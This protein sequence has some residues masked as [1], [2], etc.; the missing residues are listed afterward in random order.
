M[1]HWEEV[2][3]LGFA[4][5]AVWVSHYL[6]RWTERKFGAPK[7]GPLPKGF[8]GALGGDEYKDLDDAFP[9]GDPPKGEG[10]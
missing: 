6:G 3:F 4:I 10:E 9:A 5:V 7:T 2:A 1:S 8:V